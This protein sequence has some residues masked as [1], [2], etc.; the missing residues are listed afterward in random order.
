MT[1]TV[2]I[3]RNA[4]GNVG[5]VSL[6]V[7]TQY[8]SFW[9]SDSAGKKDVKIGTTHEPAFPSSYKVDRRLE[10][11]DCDHAVTLHKIDEPA[12]LKCWETF[13]TN[14]KSYNMVKYNCSTVVAWL[15]QEGSAMTPGSTSGI[16]ISDWVTNPIQRWLLKLK[17][18]GDQIDMWTPDDVHRYGLQI[19]SAE[20]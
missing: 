19:K 7:G 14:P 8:V 4:S 3:W 15:L 13:K 12:L 2:H 16:S 11:R 20:K 6:S 5:H 9:P 1:T 17:Y 10:Q 18:F